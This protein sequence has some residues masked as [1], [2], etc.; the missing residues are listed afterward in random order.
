MKTLLDWLQNAC[1]LKSRRETACFAL[2]SA[3]GWVYFMHQYLV[4]SGLS[5]AIPTYAGY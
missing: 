3:A 1:S 4:G 5:E 2:L